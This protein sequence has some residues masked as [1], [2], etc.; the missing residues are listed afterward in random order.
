MLSVLLGVADFDGPAAAAA[1]HD[2]GVRCGSEL[3]RLTVGLLV[4]LAVTVL[5]ELL[6]VVVSLR[7]SVLDVQPRSAMPY[8][9]YTR[10]GMRRPRPPCRIDT[11][12]HRLMLQQWRRVD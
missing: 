3:L 6:I 9:V 4:T 2:G 5:L 12:L 1:R 10:L 11:Q 7:G 8:I